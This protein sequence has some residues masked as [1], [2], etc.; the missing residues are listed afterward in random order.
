MKQ[1]SKHHRGDRSPSRLT[2]LAFLMGRRMREE[3]HRSPDDKR[4][5]SLLQFEAMRYVE[6]KKP[7]MRELAHYFSVTPPAATLLVEELVD[8]KLLARVVDKKDRRGIRLTL[9]AKGRRFM[10]AAIQEK[11]RKLE[12]TFSVLSKTEQDQLEAILEKVIKGG[13]RELD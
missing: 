7:L 13:G 10:T 11:I 4:S 12:D 8:D 5:I 6:D 9:T 3:M 1:I 2:S